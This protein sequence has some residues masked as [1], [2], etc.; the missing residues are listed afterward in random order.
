MTQNFLFIDIDGPL[1]PGRS[2]L[3]PDNREFLTAFNNGIKPPELFVETPPNFDDWG[4][5]VHNL[6]AK[7]GDAKVVI[8][9]NWRR[10]VDI[11]DL[12]DLFIEQGLQFEYADIASCA[13]RGMSSERYHDIALHMESFIKEDARC[14]IIDDYNLQ[15]L[16]L[17]YKLEDEEGE[18]SEEDQYHGIKHDD[19]QVGIVKNDYGHDVRFKWLDV[20]YTNGLTY[21]QFKLGANFFKVDWDKLNFEE[22]GIPIKTEEEKRKEREEYDKALRLFL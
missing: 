20:D 7:Y 22:F 10:W 2:H 1:L 4:V 14:L 18:R 13:R 8:V 19:T 21:E 3:F 17:F 5:R 15:P 11:S 12:Q 9:T 16:N 6:L